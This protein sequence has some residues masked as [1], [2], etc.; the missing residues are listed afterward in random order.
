MRL[1]AASPVVSVSPLLLDRA[2]LTP[3]LLSRY[4]VGLSTPECLCSCSQGYIL[5]KLL[6]RADP[7]DK[8]SVRRA[9]AMAS[10]RASQH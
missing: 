6:P 8:A 4:A 9:V 7:V 10:G 5:T 1:L 3:R 2:A